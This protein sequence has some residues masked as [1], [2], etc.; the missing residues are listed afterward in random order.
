MNEVANPLVSVI[1][2]VYNGARYV[3]EAIQSVQDYQPLE[4]I[5]IDDGSTDASADIIARYPVTYIRQKPS[6]DLAQHATRA[7]GLRAARCWLFSIR[8]INGRPANCP[9]R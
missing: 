8:T 1:L 5:V 2:P 3:A 7:S 9:L 4:C 6:A